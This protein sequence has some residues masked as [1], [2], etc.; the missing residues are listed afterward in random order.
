[1]SNILVHFA[2]FLSNKNVITNNKM[3]AIPPPKKSSVKGKVTI[4]HKIAI[5]D[6]TIN[7]IPII[8]Y[9]FILSQCPP[10]QQF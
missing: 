3:P 4:D 2:S 7:I 1:M 9:F 10:Q 5:E 6:I 8:E